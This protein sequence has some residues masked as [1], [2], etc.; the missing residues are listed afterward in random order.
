MNLYESLIEIMEG[1][2]KI[3]YTHVDY[4]LATEEAER[5]G[6]D[7]IARSS[8]TGTSHTSAGEHRAVTMYL[9][10]H[11][12]GRLHSLGGQLR[13]RAGQHRSGWV[14][15]YHAELRLPIIGCYT[16]LLS[17]RSWLLAIFMVSSSS[18]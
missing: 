3:L 5:I 6:V 17:M 15:H 8:V 1:E 10:M 9:H 11:G 2:P 7:H 4:S 14:S 16:L 13:E 12:H 18:L